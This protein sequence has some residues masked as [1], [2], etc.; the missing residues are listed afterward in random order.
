[1]NFELQHFHVSIYCTLVLIPK[2][3]NKGALGETM[4]TFWVWPSSSY[5][6]IFKVQT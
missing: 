6:H 1:M 4:P 3:F 5:A 2:N